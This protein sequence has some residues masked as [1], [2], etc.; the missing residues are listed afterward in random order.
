M[1]PSDPDT[2]YAVGQHTVTVEFKPSGKNFNAVERTLTSTVLPS[3]PK[4]TVKAV[5]L[6]YGTA[7]ADTQLSDTAKVTVGDVK[8]RQDTFEVGLLFPRVVPHSVGAGVIEAVAVRD[9]FS[10]GEFLSHLS[11]RKGRPT[12]RAPEIDV[13]AASLFRRHVRG[14]ADDGAR[15]RQM[16]VRL[17]GTG[18]AE[19][20]DLN[21]P[22]RR[23]DPEIARLEIAVNEL[24][25]ERGFE[26]GTD[27][28]GDPHHLGDRQPFLAVEALVQRFALEDRHRQERHAVVLV[29]V[30]DRDDVI[31]LDAGGRPGFAEEA[32]LRARPG[33]VL[34]QHHLE[35]DLAT[36]SQILG[37]EDDAHAAPAKLPKD[38]EVAESAE[39]VAG[40]GGAQEVEI[41]RR[42][43]GVVVVPALF[44]ARFVV[45]I[46][47]VAS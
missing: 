47:E 1:V 3:T 31:V 7:L 14:S 9:P 39:F 15:T 17:H 12:G 10:A 19:V 24:A 30:Q 6:T 23:F 4:V 35:R 41:R 27:F 37:Q 29:D 38:A 22:A 40:L 8:K 46:G 36:E 44:E 32:V 2:I 42:I 33:G 5:N 45:G 28:P 25:L 13:F 11:A 18:Q 21:P 26:A 16:L 34:R 20:E 43:G